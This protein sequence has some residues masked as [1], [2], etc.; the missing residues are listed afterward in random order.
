MFGALSILHLGTAI[1]EIRGIPWI[2]RSDNS[3]P[4][5]NK[6]KDFLKRVSKL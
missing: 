6:Q 2:I 1:L 5:I 4:W 3:L